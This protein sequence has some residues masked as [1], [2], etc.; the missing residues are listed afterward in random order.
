M[1]KITNSNLALFSALILAL[2]T[3]V[4]FVSAEDPEDASGETMVS[5]AYNP[6]LPVA[7]GVTQVDEEKAALLNDIC[8]KLKENVY[9]EYEDKAFKNHSLS[10]DLLL[11]HAYVIYES[12]DEAELNAAQKYCVLNGIDDSNVWFKYTG[13]IEYDNVFADFPADEGEMITDHALIYEMLTNF[14][15]ENN[16]VSA[17]FFDSK[18]EEKVYII[19]AYNAD[20][21]QNKMIRDFIIDNSISRSSLIFLMEESSYAVHNAD[22]TTSD[23][24][25][26]GAALVYGDLNSDGIADLTDLSLLSLYLLNDLT[27]D[28]VQ[29]EA[30]DVQYDGNVD[31]A[32]LARLKQYVCKEDIRLG[33]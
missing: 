15:S 13:Y 26:S 16:I 11:E 31:I 32:D 17:Y 21:Q 7:D 3:S 24:D 27:F 28:S 2:S 22:I 12:A 9:A 1:K 5:A 30:A 29:T 33:R 19:Y 20:K 6:G 8:I 25:I 18:E 10:V 4:P 23:T 14:T